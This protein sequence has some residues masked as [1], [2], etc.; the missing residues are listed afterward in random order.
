MSCA[1]TRSADSGRRSLLTRLDGYRRQMCNDEL[2]D[3]PEHRMRRT[4]ASH[5]GPHAPLPRVPGAVER[6]V[7]VTMG[8]MKLCASHGVCSLSRAGICVLHRSHT[9]ACVQRCVKYIFYFRTFN[10]SLQLYALDRVHRI[11]RSAWRPV[12]TPVPDA[13]VIRVDPPFF[14]ILIV[15]CRRARRQLATWRLASV[16]Q[17]ISHRGCY[18]RHAAVSDSPKLARGTTQSGVLTAELLA[19]TRSAAEWSRRRGLHRWHVVSRN[20]GR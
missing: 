19:A 12:R 20:T 3:E 13:S 16:S 10:S 18:T 1:A 17:I 2:F 11:R 9:C 6:V 7:G 15:R 14:V 5:I 4:L 8:V